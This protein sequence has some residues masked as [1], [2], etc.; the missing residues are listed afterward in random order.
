M[1]TKRNVPIVRGLANEFLESKGPGHGTGPCPRE[2]R[3]FSARFLRRERIGTVIYFLWLGGEFSPQRAA[4][5]FSPR[6]DGELKFAA[7]R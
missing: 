3:K 1:R 7:A 5:G 2:T 4:A 6:S